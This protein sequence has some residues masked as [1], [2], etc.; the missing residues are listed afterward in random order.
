VACDD[1]PVEVALEELP[2]PTATESDTDTAPPTTTVSALVSLEVRVLI[3]EEDTVVL[4]NGPTCLLISRG[5]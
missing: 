2:V 1:C 4:R 3:V 5:K